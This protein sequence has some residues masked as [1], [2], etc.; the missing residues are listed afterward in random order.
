MSGLMK[1]EFRKL[2]RQNKIYICTAI[3]I[4]LQVLLCFLNYLI[5]QIPMEGMMFEPISGIDVFVSG[6]SGGAFVTVSGIFAAL[7]VCEDYEQ[8]TIKNIFARGYSRSQVYLS[9][10]LSVI[11]GVTAM[12]LLL[13][14]GSL[15]SSAVFFG[16]EY[17]SL[18]KLFSVLGCQYLACIAYIT[19]IVAVC[20]LT[21][22]NGISITLVVLIPFLMEL[23]FKIVDALVKLE[24][25]RVADYWITNVITALGAITV[26]GQRLTECLVTA[27]L[28]MV[29]GTLLGWLFSKRV[30]L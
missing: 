7:C 14:V 15:A 6:V 16:L 9:K 11:V 17:V 19:L 25:V 20:T 28:Y 21:R 1:L 23:L 18:V 3:T 22:K 5:S 27:L 26:S 12:Y 24:S 29:G 2:I 13:M 4:F 8:T 30:E 10:L